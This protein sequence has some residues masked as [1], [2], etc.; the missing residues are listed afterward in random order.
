MKMAVNEDE[1]EW[2]RW[3]VCV[4]GVQW[5]WNEVLE[6]DEGEGVTTEVG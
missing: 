1:D 4:F 3:C 5:E 6:G 2:E